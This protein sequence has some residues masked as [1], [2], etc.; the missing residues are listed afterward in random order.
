MQ[1]SDIITNSIHT[2]KIQKTSTH[3][4][5]LLNELNIRHDDL[6]SSIKLVDA[7]STTSLKQLD[8]VIKLLQI[9][10]KAINEQLHKKFL[11]PE[12]Y[13]R[14]NTELTSITNNQYQTPLR[15][16]VYQINEYSTQK[17]SKKI[18]TVIRSKRM[19]C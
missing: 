19:G 15:L 12:E 17:I 10:N 14:L 9:H 8:T 13:K 16:N 4:S 5:E 18:P 3:W 1:N 6:P 7:V 11:H 2:K